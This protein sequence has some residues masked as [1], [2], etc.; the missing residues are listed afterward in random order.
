MMRRHRRSGGRVTELNGPA[1]RRVIACSLANGAPDAV[2]PRPM[3]GDDPRE[4][5]AEGLRRRR[6]QRR[7]WALLGVRSSQFRPFG[8]SA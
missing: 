2:A 4:L 5:Q 1:E 7:P 3:E 8:F 6:D